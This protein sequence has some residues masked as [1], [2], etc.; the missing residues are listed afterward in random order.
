MNIETFFI[1]HHYISQRE[2][3]DRCGINHSLLRQYATG[4]KKPSKERIKLIEKAI[5]EIGKELAKAK[6]TDGN[7]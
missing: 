1:K 5:N 4:Q 2:V 7:P 3:A 6:I